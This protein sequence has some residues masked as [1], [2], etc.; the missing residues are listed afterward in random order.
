MANDQTVSEIIASTDI[1]RNQ[2]AMLERALQEDIDKIRFDAFHDD[3]TL[4]AEELQQLKE[5]RAQKAEARQ[6]FTDLVFFTLQRLN[7][8]DQITRLQ[9]KM[10]EINEGL[11]DDLEDLKRIVRHA[12]TAAKI[13]DALAKATE[14]LASLAAGSPIG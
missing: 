2:L 1:A 5:L 12:A 6:A 3:R 10:N 14:K 7:Q 4:T 9:Q 8:S 11:R 13:A